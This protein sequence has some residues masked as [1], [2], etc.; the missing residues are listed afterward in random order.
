MDLEYNQKNKKRHVVQARQLAM[1]F[2]K[3]SKA[4]LAN[5]VL[6]LEIV[7]TLLYYMLVKQL[8]I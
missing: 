3:N 6:K 5:M 1:F 8:I 2:A 7:I 4:S